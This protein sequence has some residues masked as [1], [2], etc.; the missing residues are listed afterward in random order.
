MMIMETT[1][2]LQHVRESSLKCPCC[3]EPLRQADNQEFV[4]L[5]CAHGPCLSE[6]ANQPA[7][8]ETIGKA[9]ACLASR[10]NEECEA[11]EDERLLENWERQAQGRRLLEDW[12]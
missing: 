10:V 8:G 12:Q 1:T 7:I 9:F 5:W 2:T 11:I 3:R 4:E 6:Q